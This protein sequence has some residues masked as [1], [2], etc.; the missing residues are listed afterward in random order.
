MN[1]RY[2]DAIV[3]RL[4]DRKCS[5]HNPHVEDCPQNWHTWRRYTKSGSLHKNWATC[6]VGKDGTLYSSILTVNIG[7]HA[8]SWIQKG[9][10]LHLHCT[11]DAFDKNP[12]RVMIHT[13][14]LHQL[15]AP[16]HIFI[17]KLVSSGLGAFP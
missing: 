1:H 12:N 13:Q 14:N 16:Q 6:F 5:C 15:T 9:K 10:Q 17:R 4:L 2:I 3:Q 7:E 8:K 11:I